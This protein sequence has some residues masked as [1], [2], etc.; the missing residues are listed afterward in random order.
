MSQS[1]AVPAP[2]APPPPPAAPPA[3]DA[4]PAAW[5]QLL[6]EIALYCGHDAALRLVDAH[7]GTELCIPTHGACASGRALAALLG[8]TAATALIRSWPGS[9]LAIPRCAR[10]RRDLRDQAIIDAYDRGTP[11]RDLARRHQLTTRQV[12]CLPSNAWA[13]A[14]ACHSRAPPPMVP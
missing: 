5:P 10:L 14:M 12:R 11:V 9:R 1:T 7:G 4:W 8:E 3:P 6:R 2:G 13:S